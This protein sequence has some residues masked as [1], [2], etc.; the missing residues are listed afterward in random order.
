[1][2]QP[3]FIAKPYERIR[4]IKFASRRKSIRSLHGEALKAVIR[5]KRVELAGLREEGPR[6]DDC[7]SQVAREIEFD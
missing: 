5:K 3:L 1:M 6:P 4:L 2:R 7:Q